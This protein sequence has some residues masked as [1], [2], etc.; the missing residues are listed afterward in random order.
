MEPD[1]TDRPPARSPTER[2]SRKL[3][4]VM[5]EARNGR[6]VNLG[7][8]I[9]SVAA[10]VLL[11]IGAAY[12]SVQVMSAELERAQD[13]LATAISDLRGLDRVVT[14][15]RAASSAHTVQ[16]TERWTTIDERLER[17]EDRQIRILGRLPAP[18]A[19]PRHR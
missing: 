8:V 17:M 13:D 11:S 5:P 1:D 7:S 16:A 14:Q 9:T 12:V 18:R 2:L 15:L 6:F 4:S 3:R 19:A 10:A